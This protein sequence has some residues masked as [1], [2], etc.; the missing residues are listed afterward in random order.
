MTFPR[1]KEDKN[2]PRHYSRAFRT[3]PRGFTSK[4]TRQGSQDESLVTFNLTKM[5]WNCNLLANY[6]PASYTRVNSTSASEPTLSPPASKRQSK[7]L[8][9]KLNQIQSNP[10][11]SSD[12]QAS[13]TL[14]IQQPKNYRF[15]CEFVLK[16]YSNWPILCTLKSFC[17]IFEKRAPHGSI[18]SLRN[19][20]V[21]PS[22]R[23]RGFRLAFII[24]RVSF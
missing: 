18:N 4:T 24:I 6:W 1:D 3:V 16:C 13:Y 20:L 2:I 14:G 11:F 17:E 10:N 5:F 22:N 12:E 23:L 9:F 15:D 7:Q 19:G 21:V 8:R